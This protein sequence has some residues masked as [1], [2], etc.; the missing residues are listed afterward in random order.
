MEE[1]D[2]QKPKAEELDSLNKVLQ[3]E[4]M[5]CNDE[6]DKMRS[7]ETQVACE[8]QEAKAQADACVALRIKECDKLEHVE[9]QVA[10]ELQE[11]KAQADACVA[12]RIKECDKLEHAAACA[13]AKA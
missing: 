2:Q 3:E 9:T 8:L 5:Q 6:R 11:A 4:V 12:L 13:D 1:E 7:V 10:C